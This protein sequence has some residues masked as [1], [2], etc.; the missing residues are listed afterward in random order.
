MG[1][2]FNSHQPRNVVT[3]DWPADPAGDPFFRWTAGV[4]GLRRRNPGLRM[5]G[6]D[7]AGDGRFAWIAGPWMDGSHGGGH[8]TIGWRARPDDDPQHD[9]VVLLNFEPYDVLVDL[10]LGRAGRWVKLADI[11]T[12]PDG[13]D[14]GTALHSNDGRFA[15][16]VVPSS[17]GFVYRFAP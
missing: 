2:E 15:G 3:V 7:P 5:D 9:L 10:E 13:A 14:D 16:F 6:Y 1:Q 4:A 8:A 12:V 17:S 11:D